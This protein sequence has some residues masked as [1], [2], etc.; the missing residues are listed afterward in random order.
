MQA[1]TGRPRVHGM[2]YDIAD[3]KLHYLNIDFK[4]QVK[5]YQSI[6]AVTDY[7]RYQT[8]DIH[9]ISDVSTEKNE[10]QEKMTKALFETMDTDNDG[11]IPRNELSVMMCQYIDDVHEKELKRTMEPLLTTTEID[12]K[13]FQEIM[14]TLHHAGIHEK[15]DSDRLVVVKPMSTEVCLI[16]F[17]MFTGNCYLLYVSKTCCLIHRIARTLF[18]AQLLLPFVNSRLL[19]RQWLERL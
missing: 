12:Y 11:I 9:D 14:E 15:D 3:G 7:H 16:M 6:Y 5:K 19:S 4:S 1:K 17:F 18:A 2:V 10:K 13:K 8:I